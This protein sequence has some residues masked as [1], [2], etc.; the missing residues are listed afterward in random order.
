MD[1]IFGFLER[2]VNEHKNEI[3]YN[4]EPT[5]FVDAYLRKKAKMD[6]DGEE[7]NYYS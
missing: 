6:E 3:D 1:N 4:S 5:D 7:P 2:Q